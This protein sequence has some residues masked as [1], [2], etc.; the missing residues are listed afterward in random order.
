[1]RFV[2]MTTANLVSFNNTIDLM[3][4]L[5]NPLFISPGGDESRPGNGETKKNWKIQKLRNL[6]IGPLARCTTPVSCSTFV[7]I[8]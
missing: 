1:M 7:K 2:A 5:V 3:I 6:E 8:P 4:L